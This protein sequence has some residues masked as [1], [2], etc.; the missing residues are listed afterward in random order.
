MLFDESKH[1]INLKRVYDN[2]LRK[3][4]VTLSKRE[5]GYNFFKSSPLDFSINEDYLRA[6][7]YT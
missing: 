2:L 4:N 6:D 5:I 3:N 7:V 1:F